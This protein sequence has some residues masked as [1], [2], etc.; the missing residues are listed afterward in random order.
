MLGLAPI[1]SVAL[2]ATEQKLHGNGPFDFFLFNERNCA[3]VLLQGL[4][5]GDSCPFVALLVAS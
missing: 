1:F 2:P 3:F 5:Y 4:Y